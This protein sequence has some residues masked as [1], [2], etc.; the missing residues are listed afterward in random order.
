MGTRSFA[1]LALFV[2][3]V[4]GCGNVPDDPG[5]RLFAAAGVIQGTVL[6][7]GPHP[8]SFNGH[9]VGNAILLVFDRRNLPPPNGLAVISSNFADVT[10]DVLFANEPRYTGTDQPYCPAQ[11]GFTDTI[12]VSAPFAVSPMAAGSYVI[13]AFFDYTGDFLPTFKFRELPEQSDVGGG[14]VDTADALKP[15][16]SGNPDYSPHFLPIEIGTP[17]PIS[18][19]NPAGQPLPPGYIPPYDMPSA[20]YVASNVTVS[21]G[22]VLT[23]TRPYFYPQGLPYGLS[24]VSTDGNTIN[25]TTPQQ[26]SDVPGTP[27][28]PGI[29]TSKD[30]DANYLPILTIPQD[31]LTLS[32]P[33]VMDV[34]A[35]QANVN[36]FEAVLPHL[37]LKFGVAPDELPCA[38]P[39]PGATGNPCSMT[40]AAGQTDPFHFQLAQTAT[41]QGTFSVWQNA[42]FDPGTQTWNPLQIPE[43]NNA[44]MLWPEI[45][46]SKLIDSTP[47]DANG[48]PHPEDP[49]SLT[50]QGA[51]NLPVVIMQ[52]ITLL[53]PV[54]TS[55][56]GAP[57]QAD[58]LYNTVSGEGSHQLFVAAGLSPTFTPF[59]PAC[60]TPTCADGSCSQCYNGTLF[61]YQTGQPTVFQQPELTVAIRPAAICFA[62]LFDN[63]VAVDTRGTLISPFS[64]NTQAS[65]TPD[66]VTGPIVPTDI[67]SNGDV[68]HRY[69]ATSLVQN[70][71]FGCLPRG[72]YAINVVYPDGQA[73]TVPNE[74]GACSGDEGLT[75]YPDLTCTVKPRPILPSQGNRAVVEIVGPNNPM[76]CQNP[77]KPASTTFDQNT[78]PATAPAPATPVDCL[79]RCCQFPSPDPA[80]VGQPAIACPGSDSCTAVTDPNTG[81][82]AQVCLPP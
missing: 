9:I 82:Q 73:W 39:L 25:N 18:E 42:Y 67:L 68:T 16:N 34:S 35:P 14:D 65:F 41:A 32:A 38:A 62:H 19:A 80:C 69:Q 46:L 40:R 51:A 56:L 75:D 37:H 47:V 63:P 2:A 22:Q 59:D 55:A 6:Y 29:V 23:V 17:K 74:S 43:G 36:Q 24:T 52:G 78:A 79:P 3:A 54:Q 8:C 66:G 60:S 26:S 64:G 45:I 49:A 71:Q 15:I 5:D 21:I 81:S 30:S 31:I 48:N 12:T 4:V 61:N 33:N 57:A 27:G 50:A 7:Q 1:P 76:N 72:R 53:S 13:Q 77:G 70:V 28:S 20:G 44:P 58:T 11:H 10:G